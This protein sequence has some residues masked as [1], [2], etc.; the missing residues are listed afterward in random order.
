MSGGTEFWSGRTGGALRYVASLPAAA[1]VGT[2]VWLIVM[3]EGETRGWTKHNDVVALGRV[4]GANPDGAPKR[5]FVVTFV[6]F[7]LVAA[8]VS[9]LSRRLPRGTGIAAAVVAPVPF[10]VW[11]LV[12]GPIAANRA[13]EI[14]SGLFALDGGVVNPVLA[15]IA[16]Y[17]A[18]LVLVRTL[19][20][21]ESAEWWR[22][23]R[24]PERGLG[25]D[26]ASLELPE[27]RGE[28]RDELPLGQSD[29]RG[30]ANTP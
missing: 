23:G 2:L 9:A 28:E 24:G 11:G 12:V 7:F 27:E 20:V 15:A 1:I 30:R 13:P 25:V 4:F 22:P 8:V 16:S 5:G 18:S 14:P 17:L 19:R 26:V 3:Q 6:A 21:M 29:D 10:L